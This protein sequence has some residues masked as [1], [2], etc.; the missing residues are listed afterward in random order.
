MFVDIS[1]KRFPYF[2]AFL[3]LEKRIS[4]HSPNHRGPFHY[5]PSQMQPEYFSYTSKKE[6][7]DRPFFVFGSYFWRPKIDLKKQGLYFETESETSK[8]I[9]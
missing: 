3:K 8:F 5:L 6:T 4:L 1:A 9:I 7:S 2:F